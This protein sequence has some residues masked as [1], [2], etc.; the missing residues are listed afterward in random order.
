MLPAQL[1]LLLLP[2]GDVGESALMF[3]TQTPL[4]LDLEKIR[5]SGNAAV[6]E[7]VV[8]WWRAAAP[9]SGCRAQRLELHG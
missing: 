5:A 8:G 2:T 1:L 7:A 6:K 4:T 3:K 9:P